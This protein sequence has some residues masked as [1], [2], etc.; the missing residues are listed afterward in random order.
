MSKRI[1]CIL[2]VALF[3]ISRTVFSSDVELKGKIT[4]KN[5][6]FVSIDGALV[7]IV[8]L[9]D[10]TRTFYNI[11]DNE[12][13]YTIL[14]TDVSHFQSN[15]PFS[16][17]L[18]QNYPNPFNPS[19]VILYEIPEPDNISIIIYN[20]LGK[21]IKTVF[22]GYQSNRTGF[23]VWD[24]TDDMGQGMAAGI[25]LYCLRAKEV[26]LTRKM[27]LLDG[28][29]G[30]GNVF[31]Y[32]P[33]ISERI[34]EVPGINQTS[35][36]Y[37][38]SVSG[39]NIET[40]I[41]TLTIITNM[42]KSASVYRTIMDID[43][44]IYR[45]VSTGR[46]WWMEENL[47]VTHFQNGD[48]IP[49]F[50]DATQWKNLVTAA[51]CN[52]GNDSGNVS[53]FGRLYNWYAINDSHVI[54]P[55]GWHVP[56]DEE[57]K[58][59]E[60][61]IGM[62]R[63]EADKEAWR[64]NFEEGGKL[65]ETGNAHWLGENIGAT[66]ES[67]FTALPGGMRSNN[68][69]FFGLGWGGMFWSSTGYNSETAWER[70]LSA[71]NSQIYRYHE[72][73]QNGYSIRCV[74]GP[75]AP[76]LISPKKD[77]VINFFTPLF[78]WSDVDYTV[79]YELVVDDNYSFMSPEII[80]TTLAISEFT[81]SIPLQLD[82]Y[83]W[84]V[85]GRDVDG[86]RGA[87]SV[88]WHFTID[89]IGPIP[90]DLISPDSGSTINN[91]TPAF[92]WGEVEDATIYELIVDN[93]SDLSS[94]EID[95]TNLTNH[96]FVALSPLPDGRYYWTVR[97]QDHLANWGV[98]ADPWSLIIDTQAPVAPTLITPINQSTLSD[99]TPDF[100]WSDVVD[101]AKY[102]L[103]VDNNTD[104]SSPEIQQSA[105]T[106][107]AY[108]P[109]TTLSNGT[110][111]WKVRCRDGA[112]NWGIWSDTFSFTLNYIEYGSMTDYDGNTYTTVRIGNQW[113]MM[114]NLKVTHYRNGDPI[115]TGYTNTEWANL[116]IGAYCNYNN[117]EALV[118]T[119]G[120]LYNWYALNDNRNIAPEGWHVPS[121][122][123]WQ[124]LVN[125]VGGVAVAADKLRETGTTHWLSNT[126]GVTNE[127]GFT[128][129]PGGFRYS[130]GAGYDDLG[131]YDANW[132]STPN[133][134]GAAWTW[135]IDGAWP[136]IHNY[137]YGKATGASIR[138]VKN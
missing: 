47:K 60:M 38:F 79:T 55:A 28:H 101:A 61:F 106:H 20:I 119:Y 25:Y 127:F 83:Y 115:P 15:R 122:A 29:H 102:E 137:S 2:L 95:Q 50:T 9:E 41:D 75:V 64:G 1:N 117:N 84:K 85:R 32:Q 17:K 54:A 86:D 92:D 57:W 134:S 131:S 104:F 87:W 121:D 124:I 112:G 138:C 98:W 34:N 81:P 43:S 73:K 126:A 3:F 4:A 12:G 69:D 23:V 100:D 45:I 36:D 66:N 11:T 99:N 65:K 132:T 113:W 46:Q 107:S 6:I 96:E 120:R 37:L 105:L 93:N 116:E 76:E 42:E 58:E 16:Y 135:C 128:A 71:N 118:S 5:S 51:Y 39:K 103:W 74:K 19:T 44:N 133:G 77:T 24:G 94:P 78:D 90:P 109:S 97:G 88:V 70:S 18:H 130:T 31:I 62:D 49:F 33:E 26:N 59:L 7:K 22:E 89:Q 67:G 123:E 114:E 82:S 30:S 13:Y 91:N 27:L 129:L 72:N 53:I 125:F 10:S 110:Y 68:V 108:T 56:G 48:S 52:Y 21:K 111:N 40:Y 14:I 35:N 80:D 136:D 8:N 63:S